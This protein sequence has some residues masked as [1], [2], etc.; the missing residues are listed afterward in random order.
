MSCRSHEGKQHSCVTPLPRSRP[1]SSPTATW[2]ASPAVWAWASASTASASTTSL[3]PVTSALP[4]GQVTGL[5]NGAHRHA[6]PASPV[7]RV[8]DPAVRHQGPGTAC[9]GARS[10]F[11]TGPCR[12]TRPRPAAV[13]SAPGG[14]RFPCSSGRRHW[15]S[16]RRPKSSTYRCAS[17]A[18][19]AG[20]RWPSP[21]SSWPSACFWAVTGT[22]SSKLTAAGILTRAQGDYVLQSPV[23]G[24]VTAVFANEG[25]QLP[26]GAKLFERADQPR[27]RRPCARSPRGG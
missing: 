9:S 22:V 19:R 17:P 15:P 14:V 3:A 18:R 23:A 4:V 11:R 24:Q 1:A 2:T 25:D 8:S 13:R 10:R 5:V 12:R 7:S 26:S 21:R 16:S 20:S 6:S 27:R